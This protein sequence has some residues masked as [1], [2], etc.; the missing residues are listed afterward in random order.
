MRS[1]HCNQINWNSCVV[2]S[3]DESSS[4]GMGREVFLGRFDFNLFIE[5]ILVVDPFAIQLRFLV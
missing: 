5:P 3:D 4:G 1:D 2:G